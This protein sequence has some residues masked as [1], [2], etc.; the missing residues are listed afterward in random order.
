[1]NN[2]PEFL[3]EMKRKEIMEEMDTIRLEEEAAKGQTL[4]GKSLALLGKWMISNGEKLRSRDDS[5]QE[6]GSVKLANKV[7]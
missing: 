6:T 2:Y 1:M 7:M 5:S 3:S 4:L